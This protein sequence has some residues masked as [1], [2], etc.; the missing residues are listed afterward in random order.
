[1]RDSSHFQDEPSFLTGTPNALEKLP[2]VLVWIARNHDGFAVVQPSAKSDTG[3]L[4]MVVHSFFY[5]FHE[6]L[7]CCWIGNI[8]PPSLCFARRCQLS[9]EGFVDR[10]QTMGGK[11]VRILFMKWEMVLVVSSSYRITMQ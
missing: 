8:I 7:E 2:E 5:R 6:L 10:I 1:M 4:Q 11:A 9:C 3:I